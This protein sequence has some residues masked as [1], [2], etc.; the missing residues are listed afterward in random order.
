MPYVMKFWSTK[1]EN[2]TMKTRII[3]LLLCMFPQ[4]VLSQ[5]NIYGSADFSRRDAFTRDHLIGCWNFLAPRVGGDMLAPYGDFES[6]TGAEGGCTD[7]PEGW[8]CNCTGT[9]ET[10]QETS[11]IYTKSSAIEISIDA[12]ASALSLYTQVELEKNT[13]YQL[14]LWIKGSAATD[15]T[16]L[17]VYTS[18]A[19]NKYYNFDT[20]VWQ[21]GLDTENFYNMGTS[22]VK[23]NVYILT[24]NED[25]SITRIWLTR[26]PGGASQTWYLDNVQL[27][28][29]YTVAPVTDTNIALEMP[30]TSDPVFSQNKNFQSFRG[31]PGPWGTDLDGTDDCM[32]R[33]DDDTFDPAENSGHL[34]LGIRWYTTDNTTA[35]QD[36]V[37]KGADWRLYSGTGNDLGFI[38]NTPSG[39]DSITRS[40]QVFDNQMNVGVVTYENLGDTVSQG[41]IYLG[42]QA[43]TVDNTLLS[44]IDDSGDPLGIGCRADTGVNYVEGSIQQLCAWDKPLSNIDAM[45]F[46]YPHFPGNNNTKGFYF[47]PPDSLCDQ[48]AAHAVCSWDHCREGTGPDTCLTEDTG[49]LAVFAQYTEGADNNSFETYTGTQDNPTFTGWTENSNDGGTGQADVTAYYGE[50]KHG[51]LSLRME[52]VPPLGG[53]AYTTMTSPCLVVAPGDIVYADVAAKKISGNPN[54]RMWILEYVD[55]T[56]TAA[57]AGT[58]AYNGSATGTWKLYG[59]VYTTTGSAGSVTVGIYNY[60][61]SDDDYGNILI[62]TASLKVARYRTPWNYCTSGS[63]TCTYVR[64][65]YSLHNVLEDYIQA[66]D[67]YA[68]ST[69]FCLGVWLYS[70]WGGD[71]SGIHRIFNIPGTAGNNNRMILTVP[72]LGFNLYDGAGGILAASLTATSVNW[73]AGNWHYIEVCSDNTGTIAGRHYN[74]SNSTWYAWNVAGAGTGI[75]ADQDNE[76]EVGQ[77]VG[78][79]HFDGYFGPFTVGPYSATWPAY[80]WDKGKNGLKKPY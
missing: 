54:L 24:D 57:G 20:D 32:E 44:P 26:Q 46:N 36:Y 41:R 37:G 34:S 31:Q 66:E 12:S 7:C 21:A 30:I 47:D 77:A 27:Q 6:W 29:L 9:S 51:D 13:A 62:D 2:E 65:D 8:I 78:S 67:A 3:T 38:F 35:N 22:W 33:A 68:Y 10:D 28:K 76:F 53:T 63:G 48:N 75:Q 55:G 60:G 73:S 25:R 18:A 1:K 72:D 69:G 43:V 58:W 40:N 70:D 50:S 45:K 11:N 71:A 80:A 5:G 52:V 39:A 42:S 14:T 16:Y 15:G 17:Q 61:G 19:T 79:N 56:C 23:K 64:R 59:G 4:V 74:V 49:F